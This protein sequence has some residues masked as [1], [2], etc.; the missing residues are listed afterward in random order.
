MANKVKI[1]LCKICGMPLSTYNNGDKCFCHS[2]NL[3]ALFANNQLLPEY[4]GIKERIP[5]T[6]MHVKEEE[7]V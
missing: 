4:R 2:Y 1:R 5:T 3:D 6:G 7:D